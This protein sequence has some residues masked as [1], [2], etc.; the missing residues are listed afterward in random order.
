MAMNTGY[1]TSNTKA[2]GDECYTPYYAVTP[3]LKYIDK[4]LTI[5]CPFDEEW[6]AFY[7]TFKEAGYKV[8][9]SSLVEEQDF[10]TY[11]PNEPYD[12]II[13]NPPYSIKDKIFKRLTELDKP[14][15]MLVPLQ[16]LQGQKRFNDIKNCQAII[17]NKRIGY[18]TTSS[19]TF[20]KGNSF[21][22]IYLCKNILP[23]DLIFE[24]IEEFEKELF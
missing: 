23:T 4:D 19:K 5:W 1:L 14:Y 18:H 7:N 12:I 3:I 20:T 6:S 10:L 22:S 21:A 15:M 13:S 8:I 2:S 9:R 17:F 11:E 16:T 24:E